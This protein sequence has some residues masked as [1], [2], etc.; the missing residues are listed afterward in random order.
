MKLLQILNTNNIQQSSN[1]NKGVDGVGDDGGCDGVDGD[2]CGCDGGV[3]GL[4]S[5]T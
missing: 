3:D 5:N 2:D 4:T 1:L